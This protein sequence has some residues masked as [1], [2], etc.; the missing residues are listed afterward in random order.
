MSDN[1][2]GCDSRTVFDEV[3]SKLTSAKER[4]LW[5]SMRQEMI[6]GGVNGATSYLE[7]EF[8]RISAQ[9]RREIDRLKVDQLL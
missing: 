2:K 8:A 3:R 9:L 6:R 5:G 1:F 4:T 7:G